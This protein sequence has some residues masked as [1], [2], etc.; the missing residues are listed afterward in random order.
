MFPLDMFSFHQ[1]KKLFADVEGCTVC[2]KKISYVMISLVLI[3]VDGNKD[4]LEKKTFFKNFTFT[5]LPETFLQ[6]PVRHQ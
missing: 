4:Y 2:K 6:M 3:L 1:V 5:I